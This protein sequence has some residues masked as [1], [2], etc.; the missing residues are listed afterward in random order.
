MLIFYR[1]MYEKSSKYIYVLAIIK[2]KFNLYKSLGNAIKIGKYIFA[3]GFLFY[4]FLNKKIKGL[5]IRNKYSRPKTKGKSLERKSIIFAD[6]FDYYITQK[7][8]FAYAA[9]EL[10]TKN[11]RKTFRMRCRIHINL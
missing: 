5:C 3:C 6:F 9:H 10:S 11:L 2:H 8:Y 7:N 4:D 1:V